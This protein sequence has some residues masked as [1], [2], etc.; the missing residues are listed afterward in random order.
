MP[1][2]FLPGSKRRWFAVALASALA[3]FLSGLLAPHPAP[4]YA[5]TDLGV[6]PGYG[7]I[8]ANAINSRGEVAGEAT[9]YAVQTVPHNTRAYLYLGG[10]RTSL[11]VLPGASSSRAQGINSQGEATGS[12]DF[13]ASY[14]AFVYSGGKMRDLGTLPGYPNSAGVGINDRGEVAG[15]ATNSPSQPGLPQGHAF[16]YRAGRMTDLGVPPGGSERP[17]TGINASGQIVGDCQLASGL[18]R[19]F[20]YDSRTG[21]M[22]TLPVPAPYRQGWADGINDR[23]QVL[24]DVSMRDG[25][26]FIKHAVFWHGNQVTDLGTPPGFDESIG[27]GLNDRGEAVGN[28]YREDGPVKTFLR[29]HAG[30]DNALQ[31]YL[32]PDSG[33]A[34]VYRDSKMQDLND[35][36]P[37]SAGWTLEEARGINDRGQI[38]G[39]GIHN[40]IRRAFLLTPR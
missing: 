6:V 3:L 22:K 21:A 10:K 7:G 12:A 4:R 11:G 17:T 18:T 26:R 14:H 30:G 29:N 31:R 32:E 19:S 34:F 15:D 28:C 38:V 13:G 5:V 39:N 16:L 27:A 24:G 37:R 9:N 2:N 35:L 8:E 1:P 25:N 20:L 23:G 33:H 40:G 36:I